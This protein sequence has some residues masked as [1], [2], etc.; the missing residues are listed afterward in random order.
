MSW[1][2]ESLPAPAGERLRSW[3]SARQQDPS[4]PT[5]FIEVDLCA[6]FS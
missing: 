4:L 2:L 3:W 5:Y 6:T 1:M